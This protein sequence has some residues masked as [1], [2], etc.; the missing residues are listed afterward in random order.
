MSKEYNNNLYFEK[1]DIKTSCRI[2]STTYDN[3]RYLK[4]DD[5]KTT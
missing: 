3:I 2:T 5:S 4:K 1:E